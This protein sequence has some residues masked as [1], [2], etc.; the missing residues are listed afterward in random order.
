MRWGGEVAGT[1]RPRRAAR[2]VRAVLPAVLAL[3]APVWAGAPARA[4]SPE[5]SI[6]VL[7]LDG[8]KAVEVDGR[9]RTKP[10]RFRGPGP[11]EVDGR[12][13]RGSIELL[14]PRSEP[15]ASGEITKP[16]GLRVVNELPLE[17][18][19]AGTLLGEVVETWGDVVLRAQ[20]VAIRT[21]ALHRRAHPRSPDYDVEASTRGQVYIGLDGETE[22]VRE[23]VAATRG[24]VLTWDGAPI[25][26]AFHSAAGGRTASAEEVWGEALPYLVSVRI[27]GEEDSPDTYWRMRIARDELEGALAAAGV[28]VGRLERVAVAARSESD[29]V[30]AVRIEGSR[31][32]ATLSGEALRRALGASRLRSTVFDVRRAGDDFVFVGSGRGHGVGMSQWGARAL[33]R[34]GA[35]HAQI[36]ARFYPGARLE[37][38]AGRFAL[39]GAGALAARSAGLDGV[40]P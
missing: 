39:A 38:A 24:E 17:D 13:V 23:A 27:R 10:G 25:L 34:N 33:A 21:Y 40:A 28:D 22:R 5:P 26:A 3:A 18:Y 8:A 12:R 14:V 29:R 20:A 16:G 35:S 4:A 15:T 30:R 2:V 37:R 6:R 36:L 32:A 9:T 31:D 1:D 11:H 19:V 7:L